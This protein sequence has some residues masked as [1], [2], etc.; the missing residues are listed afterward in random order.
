M[1]LQGDSPFFTLPLELRQQIYTLYLDAANRHKAH[2]KNWVTT[3]NPAETFLNHRRPPLRMPLPPLLLTCK[4]LFHEISPTVFESLTITLHR[5]RGSHKYATALF[6]FG[7]F[8]PPRVRKLTLYAD[9]INKMVPQLEFLRLLTSDGTAV[10]SAAGIVELR[11]VYFP[12]G[13]PE[14]SS[15]MNGKAMQRWFGQALLKHIAA[16]KMLEVVRLWGCP[17]WWVEFLEA[18]TTARVIHEY[19]I[20]DFAG[21]SFKRGT[22]G[23]G[24]PVGFAP[25][26]P[27][28]RVR[29]EWF[30][31]GLESP[32][33]SGPPDIPGC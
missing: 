15:E 11:V 31:P 17:T 10:P 6:F 8:D 28:T 2:K 25:V 29:G 7:K 5:I 22:P 27:E 20:Q 13:I 9:A 14:R 12:W 16:L 24:A 23:K 33:P 1:N 18:N 4:R 30:V 32:G 19:D 3:D 21:W 26:F